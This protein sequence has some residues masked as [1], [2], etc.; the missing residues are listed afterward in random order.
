MTSSNPER[1]ETLSDAENDANDQVESGDEQVLDELA[2]MPTPM[3]ETNSDLIVASETLPEDLPGRA[4]TTSEDLSELFGST[5][6]RHL[7]DGFVGSGDE[8][9]DNISQADGDD[10]PGQPKHPAGA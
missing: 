10:D 3:V 2:V 9:G 4:S 1:D 7:A 6:M 8:D 5:S